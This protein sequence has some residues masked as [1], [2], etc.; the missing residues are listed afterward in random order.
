[1]GFKSQSSRELQHWQRNPVLRSLRT[2]KIYT[3][4]TYYRAGDAAHSFPPTGGLGLNS[5]LGDVHNL[6]YK[7]ALI[8]Q[9]CAGSA[10]LGT[11]QSDRRQV[12]LVNSAQ[13]VK[14]G[15]QIFGLLKTL[16]TTDTDISIAKANLYNRITDPV[17]RIEVL[18]GVEAQREHFDNLGLHIGYVYGDSE[19]P[20]SASL[21]T[22]SYRAGARLPHAWLDGAS[23]ATHLPKLPAIDNTYVEELTATALAQ[24]QFS[25][26]DLCAFNAFTFIFSSEFAS[27]WS[28]LLAELKLML[29]K[30]ATQALKINTAILGGDFEL[31]PGARRNEWV[32][33]LQLDH[34]A[35][36]LVRPDQHILG[37]YQKET[38]VGEIFRELV[39]HLGL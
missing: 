25:T 22:P 6:A 26:L 28:Q 39:R 1:M 14:N 20:A 4:N 12:A 21:Y 13:S 27:H 3:T 17:T 15:L 38:S 10:L 24:K 2:L 8:H 34:G 31:V 35:A 23:K 32:M 18:K 16:G 11:Y 7:L 19:I 29:P 30:S 9:N 33:G 36:V 37:C 5:G